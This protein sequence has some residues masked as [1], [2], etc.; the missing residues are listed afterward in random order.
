MNFI[1][2]LLLLWFTLILTSCGAQDIV[3][4]NTERDSVLV[5]AL[6]VENAARLYCA[7]VECAGN[8]ELL[9]SDVTPYIVGID[10]SEYDLDNNGGIVA[11]LVNDSWRIDMEKAGTG[12]YEFTEGL[13]PSSEDRN[14]VIEDTD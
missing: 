13:T 12:E 8:Q 1:K 3:D 9:W 10:Y 2:A 6:A 5:D 14:A 7:Q 4:I 11:R